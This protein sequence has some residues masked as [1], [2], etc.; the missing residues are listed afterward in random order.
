[1]RVARALEQSNTDAPLDL[2]NSFPHRTGPHE[3]PNGSNPISL[4]SV[5]HSPASSQESSHDPFSF[6]S[7][8]AV[9]KNL[10]SHLRGELAL[11]LSRMRCRPTATTW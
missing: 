3:F 9:M 8:A 6:E 5:P 1:M 11:Q 4:C 10:C 7:N 2:K